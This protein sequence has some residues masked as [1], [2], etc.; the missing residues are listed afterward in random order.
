LK[1]NRI[2]YIVPT[3]NSE[4]Y[5]KKTI[6]SIYNN[7]FL[8]GDEIVVI[9]DCSSDKTSK[10]LKKLKKQKKIQTLIL[11]KRNVGEGQA[12]NIGIR[13]S[14]NRYFFCLDHDNIL[15]GNSVNR[16]RSEIDEYSAVAFDTVKYF[17][18]H[19]INVTHK[20]TFKP[21]LMTLREYESK[22]N[23]G[24]NG[25]VLYQ[26]Q[27][28]Q[29]VKGFDSVVLESWNFMYKMLLD[30]MKVYIVSDS[31]YFHRY[32]HESAY[33]RATKD[34]SWKKILIESRPKT[35]SGKQLK[36]TIKKNTRIYPFTYFLSTLVR[37][38]INILRVI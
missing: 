36:Y 25:N 14:K 10:I 33:T 20:D 30:E 15:R 23:P 22:N 31:H 11:L 8:D 1:N 38:L 37:K 16:L 27:A 12:K 4:K 21:G 32:G 2:S 18:F 3:F 13:K 34:S 17:Q 24:F 35:M 19:P 5:I 26:K 6:K 29:K 7:N 9:D 28:W